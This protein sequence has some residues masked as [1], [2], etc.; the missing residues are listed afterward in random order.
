MR[1][2]LGETSRP[3]YAVGPLLPPGFG[4]SGLSHAAKQMDIAS[5]Q[6]GGEFQTFLDDMLKSHGERSVIYVNHT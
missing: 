6:N 5:S 3:V 1:K 4:D 2:W